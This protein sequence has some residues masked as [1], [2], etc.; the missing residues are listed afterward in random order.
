[1]KG[2]CTTT[3]GHESHG[4]NRCSCEFYASMFTFSESPDEMVMT[5][6]CIMQTQLDWKK[7]RKRKK[8]T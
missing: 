4:S 5:P 8:K 7:I 1:M 3:K 2:H 6:E